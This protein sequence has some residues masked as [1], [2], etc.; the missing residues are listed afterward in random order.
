[1]QTLMTFV[2][3]ADRCQYLH[4]RDWQFEYDIVGTATADE[5]GERLRRG[6]RRFGHALFRPVCPSCSMCRSLRIPVATFTADRSQKRAWKGNDGVVRLTIG[7]PAETAEKR[8]LFEAF[9]SYQHDTKGWSNG[10]SDYQEMFV[11]NP[12]PT[13]EWSYYLDD[14]LIAVGYVDRLE[15]GLSAIYFYYD[16]RERHRSLGTFN[17]LS[18]LRAADMASLPYVYL[19]YYV[20]GCRSLEY[21]AR[22]RPHERL[23][24]G[25]WNLI[26]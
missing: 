22:F 4:D 21:K 12:F 18:I 10:A 17:V 26:S 6:W 14:R 19:G 25:H 11:L 5:Y 24:H 1:M 16:P 15:D 13:E 9:H 8:A 7:S 3:A 20:N 2:S 23:E